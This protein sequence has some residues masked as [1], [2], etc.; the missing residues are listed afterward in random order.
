MTTKPYTISIVVSG[1]QG[2]VMRS[3]HVMP[4]AMID[5]LKEAIDFARHYQVVADALAL[6]LVTVP[7][8]C[9]ATGLSEGKAKRL[10]KAAG[11]KVVHRAKNKIPAY[12]LPESQ[13]I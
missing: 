2:Q 11:A 5:V 6:G 8:V 13:H 10:I 3:D 4:L 7:A 12:G 9:A 1:E